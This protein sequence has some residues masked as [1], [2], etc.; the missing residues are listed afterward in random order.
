MQ[1]IETALPGVLELRPRVFGDARGFFFESWQRER[2]AKL[3]MPTEFVQD[4]V[5]RS[6]RG[7][8]RGLHV[9]NPQAQGKLVQVLDGA[10]FDVAVDVR[11]GSP[12]FGRWAGVHLR[13]SE[14]N[15]LWIPAG[16]AHGFLVLS[17]TALFQYKCTASYCAECEFSIR[18]DDPEIGIDWPLDVQPQLSA[19]DAAAPRLAGISPDRL[20]VYA[21]ERG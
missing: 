9:Q 12:S 20:P 4:N 2:Y 14:H 8:L 17:D 15:Q 21:G 13:A 18:Y 3:G 7:V 10:V 6:A 19:K 5:S 11:R 16:F 1:C